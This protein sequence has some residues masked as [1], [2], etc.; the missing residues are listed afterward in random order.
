ML[1]GVACHVYS[2]FCLGDDRFLGSYRIGGEV[3]YRSNLAAPDLLP[4]FSHA[5]SRP[6]DYAFGHHVISD[7]GDKRDDDPIFGLYRKCGFWTH[8]EAAILH[9]IARMVPGRWCDIGAHTGWTAG[10]LATAS[11]V[12]GVT[13]IDPMLDNR[14]FFQRAFWN[15][16]RVDGRCPVLLFPERSEQYFAKRDAMRFRGIVID[17]DHGA[18]NPLNDAKMAAAHLEPDGV[19]LLHDF[20]GG[21][22]QDAVLYLM[23]LGFSCRVYY[24]PHMVACCWRGDF[25]PPDHVPE[26]YCRNC[27]TD[28]RMNGFPFERTI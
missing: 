22:V 18:P 25:K 15:L 16:S 7:W 26:S 2:L 11:G 9:N 3:I 8:D 10:H 20:V 14:E 24:T 6:M 23:D 21:P 1:V 28:G 4:A 5:W 27:L 13:A 12:T 17:A 19:I